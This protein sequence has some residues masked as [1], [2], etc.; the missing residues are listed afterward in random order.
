M[1]ATLLAYELLRYVRGVRSPADAAERDLRPGWPGVVGFYG[2]FF[3]AAILFLSIADLRTY[4]LDALSPGD[5]WVLYWA[6]I[7]VGAAGL[8]SGGMYGFLRHRLVTKRAA[9][10]EPQ[11]RDS[12]D[13]TFKNMCEGVDGELTQ[14]VST[15]V[16][17]LLDSRGAA[18]PNPWATVVPN[19]DQFIGESWRNLSEQY[20][21][22]VRT[23]YHD[24]IEG[25]IRDLERGSIAISGER[26]VG[27]TSLMRAASKTFSNDPLRVL[28]VWISAPTAYDEKE[29]LFSVL[30]RVPLQIGLRLTDNPR[31][32]KR[33]PT[34]QL[35]LSDSRK[36][37][38]LWAIPLGIIA[39]AASL[40]IPIPLEAKIALAVSIVPAP[41]LMLLAMKLFGDLLLPSKI[42]G[43]VREE[44]RFIVWES[45]AL[46][47]E[48]RFDHKEITSSSVNVAGLGLNMAGSKGKERTR[49]PFTLPQLISIWEDF[50]GRVATGPHGFNKVV[51]FID[52]VDKAD[53][54]RQMQKFMR[55]LKT[56]YG[57]QKL[58]F[59]VSI[60]EDAYRLFARRST[61]RGRR[62]VFDRAFDKMMLLT[63]MSY[64]DTIKLINGRIIGEDLPLP[65]IQL[66]WALSNGN[67]RDSL[68]MAR[69]VV[70]RNQVDALAK[71]ALELVKEYQ[72]EPLLD[73]IFNLVEKRLLDPL[74]IVL[75]GFRNT[76]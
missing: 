8:L 13:L 73:Q 22:F 28:D 24:E 62:D 16:K 70:R 72:L 33:T 58:I 59:I 40:L 76:A 47:Q 52:E 34:D 61:S 15:G 54:L 50:I 18:A 2:L 23:S 68:R 44:N 75:T 17:A 39:G 32:P 43:L 21:T 6:V 53:N 9:N 38:V 46:L 35:Q 20:L 29:F 31:F 1:Y 66:I 74:P 4:I 55:I 51:I 25:Y 11:Q 67:T 65:F 27:K 71:V 48:L 12:V 14:L 63:S 64:D 49:R 3:V 41:A 10:L 30:A 69:D 19:Y 60:A 37:K 26:G 42:P 7:S 5:D 56:L 45:E 36:R 57:P